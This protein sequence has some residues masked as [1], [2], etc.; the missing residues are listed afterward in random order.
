MVELASILLILLSASLGVAFIVA[1]AKIFVKVGYN[2][3]LCLLMI[4]PVV[5]LIVVFW[6]ACTKWPIYDFVSKDWDIERLK[7]Q[8][9]KI[10]KQLQSLTRQSGK[11]EAKALPEQQVR[12]DSSGNEYKMTSQLLGSQILEMSQKD[13]LMFGAILFII[14]AVVVSVVILSLQG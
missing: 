3:W 9:E 7:V 6:F 14:I 13:W 11:P 4:L 2:R 1:W 8:Q 10:R 12:A 5:S